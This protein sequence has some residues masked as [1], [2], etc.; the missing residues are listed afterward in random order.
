MADVPDQFV[1][2][3]V[4]DV[5]QCDRQ[6]DHPETCSQVTAVTATALIVSALNSSATCRR[7][8]ALMRRKSAGLLIELRM[9]VVGFVRKSLLGAVM[10]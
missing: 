8:R 6:F 2:R 4:E 10:L 9:L 5:M 7:C 3:G 1:V